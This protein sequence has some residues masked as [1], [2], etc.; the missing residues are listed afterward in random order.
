[1]VRMARTPELTFHSLQ[2]QL[3]GIGVEVSCDTIWRYLPAAGLSF[4]KNRA[5]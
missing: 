5:G 4:K 1:M 3:A 2:S